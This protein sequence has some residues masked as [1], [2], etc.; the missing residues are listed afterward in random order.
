[1]NHQKIWAFLTKRLQ[2]L[3]FP[4]CRALERVQFFARLRRTP[5]AHLVRTGCTSGECRAHVGCASGGCRV[6]IRCASGGCRVCVGCALGARR[7]HVRC[8]S[9]ERWVV[10]RSA[11]GCDATDRGWTAGAHA[12][13]S[14]WCDNGAWSSSSARTPDRIPKPPVTTCSGGRSRSSTSTSKRTRR[15]CS[16]CWDSARADARCR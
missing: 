16:G 10:N 11:W 5:D 6:C 1:V 12:A 4:Q 7:E 14:G 15:S 2:T 13:R 9:A 8:Q 3:Q